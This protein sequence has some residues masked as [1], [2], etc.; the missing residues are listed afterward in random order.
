MRS[1]PRNDDGVA[2]LEFV[3]VASLLFLLVFGI[4]AFGRGFSTKV[5]VAG[6]ARDAAR[7]AAL[8][9]PAPTPPPGIAV[10]VN[11]TCAAGDTTN[12]ARVTA[13]KDV[14]Y[15]V[16]FWRAG[17]WHVSETVRMRCGG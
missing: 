10:I 7:A 4:F 5:A 17:T 15:D 16:P 1:H 3:L 6:A 11:A 8:R 12:D 13:S 14:P 9:Q 2:A